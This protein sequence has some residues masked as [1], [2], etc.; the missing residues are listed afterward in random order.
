MEKVIIEGMVFVIR[1]VENV[2]TLIL[3]GTEG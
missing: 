2:Y 1:W 3:I